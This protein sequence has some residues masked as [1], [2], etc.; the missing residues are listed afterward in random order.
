MRLGFLPVV[1]A[2]ILLLP[3]YGQK[4]TSKEQRDQKATQT[5]QQQPSKSRAPSVKAVASVNKPTSDAKEYR[6]TDQTKGYLDALLSPNNLP[7]VAL[8]VIGIVGVIV[9]LL[10][11]RWLRK[12]TK[13]SQSQVD[14]MQRQ[15]EPSLHIEFVRSAAFEDGQEPVFFVKLIN[16]G[17]LAAEKVAIRVHAETDIGRTI[18][19]VNDQ[20]I[21]IPAHD[22][23]ECFLRSGMTLDRNQIAAYNNGTIALR[24][25]GQIKWSGKTAQYCYKYNPWPSGNRPEGVPVFVPCDFETGVNTAIKIEA[26]MP[27][28]S[29][30]LTAVKNEGHSEEP[31]A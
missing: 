4:S 17:M 10:N 28:M 13:A 22:S 1:A 11:L 27:K 2:V 8:S 15:M 6:H 19:Y 23:R 29:A 26:A 21:T 9:A 16:S 20:V 18:G 5:Q 12:Q 3:I 31:S 24:I 14:L 30:G 25:S 7:N